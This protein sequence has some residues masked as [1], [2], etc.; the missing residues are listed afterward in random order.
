MPETKPTKHSYQQKDGEELS[1]DVDEKTLSILEAKDTELKELREFKENIINNQKTEL[2]AKLSANEFLIGRLSEDEISDR[3]K[4]LM[5]KSPEI[6]SEIAEVVGDHAELSAFSAFIKSFMKK[7]KGATIAQA[8]KAWKAKG[9]GKLE[10][11]ADID[12]DG[13]DSE[14]AGEEDQPAQTQ[15]LTGMPDKKMNGKTTAELSAKAGIKIEDTDIGMY[16]F[17]A[18]T[19]K[20]GAQ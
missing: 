3:E 18:G 16:N 13:E 8:A 17:L 10:D 5:E 19:N 11:E 4:V 7:T 6:L 20:G 12:K 15:S 14:P 1:L 2:A 9:K